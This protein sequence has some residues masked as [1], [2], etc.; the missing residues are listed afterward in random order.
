MLE[1]FVSLSIARF[2]IPS[3]FEKTSRLFINPLDYGRFICFNFQYN[4]LF[5]FFYFYILSLCSSR[6]NIDFIIHNRQHHFVC[7]I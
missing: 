6:V 1:N 3:V 4:I 5:R 2:D 7:R